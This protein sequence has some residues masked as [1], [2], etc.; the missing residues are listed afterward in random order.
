MPSGSV[1]GWPRARAN[2][3]LAYWRAQ[4]GEEHPI[5]ALPFD[6]PRP[7]VESHRG[8]TLGLEIDTALATR[9]RRVAKRH[10]ASVFMLLLTAFQTLLYRYAGQN[11]VRVG[12]PVANRAIGSSNGLIGFFVNTLV[13]R[14][15]DQ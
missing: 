6:K 14:A 15:D 2:R 11:D 5:L 10:H 4:L 8:E 12:V 13:L 3:Q 9:L 7:T 1:H